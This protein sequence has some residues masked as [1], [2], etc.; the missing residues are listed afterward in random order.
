MR[1]RAEKKRRF[2]DCGSAARTRFENFGLD[3]VRMAAPG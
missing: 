3:A 1:L 2:A